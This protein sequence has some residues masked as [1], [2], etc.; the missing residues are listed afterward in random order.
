[1]TCELNNCDVMDV[2]IVSNYQDNLKNTLLAKFDSELTQYRRWLNDFIIC[3]CDDIQAYIKRAISSYRCF[4][5]NL[6]E[7]LEYIENEFQKN[8]SM[9]KVE[10]GRHTMTKILNLTFGGFWYGQMTIAV[11]YEPISLTKIKIIS[12][13]VSYSSTGTNDIGAGFIDAFVVTIG[14]VESMPSQTNITQPENYATIWSSLDNWCK[15]SNNAF[16]LI[17]K[18]NKTQEIKFKNYS[19]AGYILTIPEGTTT[20]FKLI[21]GFQRLRGGTSPNDYAYYQ[22]YAGLTG[23]IELVTTTN[24]KLDLTQCT[25]SE[26][27]QCECDNPCIYGISETYKKRD[28]TYV[29]NRLD[30]LLNMEVCGSCADC[31]TINQLMIDLAD[32]Q[33]CFNSYFACRLKAFYNWSQSSSSKALGLSKIDISGCTY[34]RNCKTYKGLDALTQVLGAYNDMMEY[35]Q[36]CLGCTLESMR[37]SLIRIIDMQMDVFNVMLCIFQLIIDW[38]EENANRE[39]YDLKQYLATQEV[40]GIIVQRLD[41]PNTS[42]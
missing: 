35:Q 7:S 39:L 22:P 20:S 19:K 16:F 38:S 3:G 33:R 13:N 30:N 34:D 21:A 18:H 31:G 27:A 2:P 8:I 14:E 6:V 40:Q 32:Y 17:A 36:G 11:V 37:A 26:S 42:S 9:T 15:N 1:M 4:D 12:T 23:T 41:P 24:T 28:L 25:H 5:L 29:A 10:S